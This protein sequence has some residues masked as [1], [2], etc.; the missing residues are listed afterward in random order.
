M[1]WTVLQ[2]TLKLHKQRQRQEDIT[3]CLFDCKQ[4]QPVEDIGGLWPTGIYQYY[5]TDI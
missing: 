1:Y 2:C 3:F 4:L 5:T